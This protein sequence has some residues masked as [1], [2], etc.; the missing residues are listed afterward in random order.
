L[1]WITTSYITI[2]YLMLQLNESV[3]RRLMTIL[4]EKMLARWMW[5]MPYVIK[6]FGAGNRLW[7]YGGHLGSFCCCCSPFI[8]YGFLHYKSDNMSTVQS[9]VSCD[10]SCTRFRRAWGKIWC[11]YNDIF[12]CCITTKG[13]F[14]NAQYFYSK[15]AL[16]MYVC[17]ST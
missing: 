1:D 8:H 14:I 2:C 7:G 3:V 15:V 13:T 6:W 10:K 4:K 12:D 11:I 17:L 9:V 5:F 16:C